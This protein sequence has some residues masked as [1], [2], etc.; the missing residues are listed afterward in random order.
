MKRNDR[1]RPIKHTLEVSQ[2]R[3]FEMGVQARRSKRELWTNPFLGDRAAAWRRGW[4]GR[5]SVL[6][7]QGSTTGLYTALLYGFLVEHDRPDG[8]TLRALS[9]RVG[10]GGARQA[11]GVVNTLVRRGVVREVG[12]RPG[13]ALRN[14]RVRAYRV[15]DVARHQ[16]RLVPS[17]VRPG[18]LQ[19]GDR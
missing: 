5:G 4:H 13:P 12:T 8:W 18:G 6:A 17:H 3:A 11:N 19:I 7:G 14:T 2:V 15:V 9:A 10:E 1:G 16:A